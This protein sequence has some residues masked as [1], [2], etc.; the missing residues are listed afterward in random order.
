MV[1]RAR[2]PGFTLIELLVVIA[3]I[4]ILIGLL[5]PAVQKVRS[6]AARTTCQNNLHQLGIAAANYEGAY[7][8]LPPGFIG[9]PTGVISNAG[10]MVGCL[11]LLL[12]YMEQGP[13]DAAMRNGMPPTYFAIQTTNPSPYSRW[14]GGAYPAVQAAA[15]TTIPAYLCPSAV[16]NPGN[17]VISWVY[18]LTTNVPN[19]ISINWGSLGVDA[20]Y[21][22]TNY[23]G[24]GGYL[25]ALSTSFQGV[26]VQNSSLKLGQISSADGTSNT[27][28]F[29]ETV[30]GSANGAQ[31]NY[32]W[33]GAG[34]LPTGFGLRDPTTTGFWSFSSYHDGV[35]NFVMCDGAVRTIRLS[36]DFANY[37]N[38]SGWNDGALVDWSQVE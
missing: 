14:S 4:A 22:I 3:I 19:Q 26:Y 16:N 31:W 38:A 37:R 10:P 33:M 23:M 30:G 35:V 21:G 9:P 32:A 17:S 29:G 13:V 5:V 20:T 15:K 24:C 18:Y 34:S 1:S 2:R 36:A 27:F 25:G 11:A 8:H 12:P 7:K 6:A 28:A